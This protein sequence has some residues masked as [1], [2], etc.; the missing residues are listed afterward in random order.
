M[1]SSKPI[2]EILVEKGYITQQQLDAALSVQGDG[3]VG[4]LMIT[5]GFI[6]QEQLDE[7]YTYADITLTDGVGTLPTDLYNPV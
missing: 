1:S 3:Q 4:Q 6:T 7:F 5:W 2:G